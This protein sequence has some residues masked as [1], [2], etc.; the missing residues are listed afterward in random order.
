MSFCNCN[1]TLRNTGTPNRQRVINSGGKL[2]AVRTK[3][4]DGT[5]NQILANAVIDPAY[6]LDRVNEADESKRWY[7]IGEFQNEND[8]RADSN[9]ETLTSGANLKTRDGVRTYTGWLINYAAE[10]LGVLESFQCADFGLF[11][12]DPCGALQ[13]A[14]TKDGTALRPVRVNKDSWNPTL[15]KGMQ[16]SVSKVQLTFDFSQ[17]ERDKDLRVI[18]ESE[19]TADLLDVEGLLPLA[20]VISGIS[21][22]GFTA[23]LTVDYDVFLDASKDVVP[24]WVAA[25][26]EL[27]NKTT[28]SAVP[29]TSVTEVPEGTYAFVIPAQTAADVLELTNVKT[30]AQKAGF[31]LKETITIP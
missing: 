25:D 6:I 10:Y 31:D 13:G 19:I 20:A 9:F 30:A 1:G 29:I 15:M 12:V 4:D 3:A 11:I 22:I 27:F 23:A 14:I 8:V 17:L 24:A 7:P 5:F 28:N 16:E 18:S 21:A 26:F 2:I